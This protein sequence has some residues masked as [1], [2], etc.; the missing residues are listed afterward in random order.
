LRYPAEFVDETGKLKFD[1]ME[2][3]SSVHISWEHS[4]F[5][6]AVR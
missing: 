5:S 6:R 4:R 3:P 2:R 1:Y